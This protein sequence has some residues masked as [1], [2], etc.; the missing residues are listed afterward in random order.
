[1]PHRHDAEERRRAPRAPAS[2][3]AKI[4]SS[5]GSHFTARAE[6]VGTA[7]CRVVAPRPLPHGALLR[8]LLTGAH[9]EVDLLGTVAWVSGEAPWRIGIAFAPPSIAA[10]RAWFDGLEPGG[11]AAAP[12]RAAGGAT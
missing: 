4:V 11:E 9:G 12:A 2:C 8:V 6:D 3:D 5:G 7:G 10:A 1:M